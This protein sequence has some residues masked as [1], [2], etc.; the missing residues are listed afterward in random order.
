MLW[1]Q[2]KNRYL[3]PMKVFRIYYTEGYLFI[4]L[5]KKK[6]LV[7]SNRKTTKKKNLVFEI[8]ECVI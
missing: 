8:M 5:F 2:H 6:I 1:S 7:D 4:H 3:N